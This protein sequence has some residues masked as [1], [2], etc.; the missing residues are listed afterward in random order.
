MTR[1]EKVETI[2]IGALIAA[3]VS[4]VKTDGPWADFAPMS[5]IG[6]IDKII[7]LVGLTYLISSGLMSLRTWLRRN[8]RAE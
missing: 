3:G 2:F 6:D 4:Y 5:R 1:R 7:W 8:E